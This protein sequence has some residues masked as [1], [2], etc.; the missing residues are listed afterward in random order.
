MMTELKLLRGQTALIDAEDLPKVRSYRWRLSSKGYVI[1]TV[2]GVKPQKT[3][4]L[5]RL[6]L[7]TPAGL[8]TDHENHDK[9]NN[10]KSNLRIATYT[11]NHGNRLKKPSTASRFKGVTWSKRAGK[12]KAQ[13]SQQTNGQHKVIGLGEFD[14]EKTAALAYNEA[15]KAY[16]GNFAHINSI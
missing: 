12:W 2:A 14:D 7:D 1:A 3:I 15:A 6:I 8:V 5:H 10:Q 11:N 4:W 9:L 13:I 16:F